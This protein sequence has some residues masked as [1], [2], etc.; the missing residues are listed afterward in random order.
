[1]I[2]R[3]SFFDKAR[4]T[5]FGGS[6]SKLQVE[7]L[8]AI[9]DRWELHESAGDIRKLAYMLATAHHETGKTMQ[10]IDEWGKGKGLPYGQKIRMDRKPYTTPDKLYYGR[11]FVQLTWY[12]NYDKAGRKL[13]LDLLN[14]PDQAKALWVASDI[15]Y[16]GMTEGWFT[17]K[18][19]SDYITPSKCDFVNARRIINGTDKADL[20]AGYATLYHN[21]LT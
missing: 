18:K 19:L 6:L 2:N 7:G 20:I 13:G 5:L 15:M 3:K 9:I 1:M 4:L 21:A 8:T 14:N 11:G 17:G 16:L 12:D 10:P